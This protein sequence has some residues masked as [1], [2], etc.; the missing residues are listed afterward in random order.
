MSKAD[1]GVDNEDLAA[2]LDKAGGQASRLPPIASGSLLADLADVRKLV[3]GAYD[4]TSRSADSWQVLDP[5]DPIGT[6]GQLSVIVAHLNVRLVE[7]GFR[8][9]ATN[10]WTDP[11]GFL[12]TTSHFL[13]SI[14]PYVREPG[15]AIH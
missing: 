2:A 8:P 3:T 11:F 4:D 1:P 5:A 6:V 9:P 15:A 12:T 13:A 7:Q 14:A 10:Y